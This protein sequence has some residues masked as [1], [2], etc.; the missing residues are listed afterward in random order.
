MIREASRGHHGREK[1]E[2][3]KAAA[4][5]S[6]G[7]TWAADALSF[8]LAHVV[9]LIGHMDSEIAALDA[10]IAEIVDGPMAELLQTIP[11][12][13]PVNA[14]VILAEVGDPNRFEDPSKL[15]AYAGIDAS[16]FQS[17]KFDGS[18]QHMSKRGSSHLRRALMYAADK[19]RMRDPYFGD[20]YDSLRARGKHHYVA[21]SGV[22]RKLCGVILA[23]MRERRPYEKRPSIQSRRKESAA[24]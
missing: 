8:E 9:A 3:V 1:A 18:E 2:E 13:G 16:K 12:V 20:Y 5:A 22:A 10:K 6:V 17:G 11:G 23:V 4:K 24:D 15:F 19:A 7:S 14:A 21:V